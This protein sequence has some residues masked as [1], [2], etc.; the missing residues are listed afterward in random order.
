MQ[1]VLE[2]LV[3]QL[4]QK[5]LI[6]VKHLIHMEYFNTRK[7]VCR[8]IEDQPWSE[9]SKI[10]RKTLLKVLLERT[11]KFHKFTK[12]KRKKKPR[13]QVQTKNWNQIIK[14]ITYQI[15][16]VTRIW[17]LMLQSMQFLKQQTSRK[18]LLWNHKKKNTK[19]SHI[20]SLILQSVLLGKDQSMVRLLLQRNLLLTKIQIQGLMSDLKQTIV[21]CLSE[22]KIKM[23]NVVV[24]ESLYQRPSLL[25]LSRI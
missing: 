8:G 15:Q 20:H 9:I 3:S 4:M 13:N 22:K 2:Q 12:F 11:N 17:V 7:L 14:R 24:Q 1:D 23:E 21:F 25:H 6:L 5:L 19:R 10:C 18:S 16:K